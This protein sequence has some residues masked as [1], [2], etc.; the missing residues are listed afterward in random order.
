MAWEKKGNLK[1]PKGD[2]G[3]KGDSGT[4]GVPGATGVTMTPSTTPQ[5]GD[6][7]LDGSTGDVYQF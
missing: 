5:A 6:M 7:C 2:K 1:G 4:N 3:D